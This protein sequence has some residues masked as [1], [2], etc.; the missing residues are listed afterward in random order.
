MRMEE[1]R[2]P[3]E[4]M[5]RFREMKLRWEKWRWEDCMFGLRWRAR[6]VL[7]ETTVRMTGGEACER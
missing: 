2:T 7:G 4:A 1:D 5:R 6:Q 3:R